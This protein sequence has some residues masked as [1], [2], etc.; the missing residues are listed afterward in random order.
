[1]KYNRSSSSVF[2][3]RRVCDGI[4]AR[5]ASIAKRA[6]STREDD[7]DENNA[8]EDGEEGESVAGDKKFEEIA[9]SFFE[10]QSRLSRSSHSA[11]TRC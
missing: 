11:G 2:F 10:E 1:M 8:K 9:E 4:T 5:T 3:K 7:D 6:G